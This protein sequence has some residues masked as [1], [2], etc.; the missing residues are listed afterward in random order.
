MLT[1]LRGRLLGWFGMILLPVVM[2]LGYLAS[3]TYRVGSGFDEARAVDDVAEAVSQ[4][5]QWTTDYSLTWKPDSLRTA[6]AWATRYRERSAR[7]RGLSGGPQ[8]AETLDELDRDFQAY[9]KLA[10]EMANAYIKFDRVVGNSFTDRFHVQARGLEEETRKLK[11]EVAERM[12][13]HLRRGTQIAITAS[14]LIVAIVVGGALAISAGLVRRLRAVLLTLQTLA[15]GEGDLTR[16]LTDR[17][18]DEIGTLARCF[19]VFVDKLQGII[20]QVVGTAAH[21]SSASAQLSAASV[22]LSGGTQAQSAGLEETAASLEQM[23]GTVQQNAENA[24]LADQLAGRAKGLAESGAAEIERAVSAM[25]GIAAAS[26]RISQIT[27]A[28]DEI[29]FQT[30]LLALNAAVE[31]ARAGEQGRGFAV[32]AAEVRSL[33]QRSAAAAKEIKSLIHEASEKVTEGSQQVNRSGETLQQIVSEV[34]RVADGIREIAR[35]SQ[36]QAQG[37]NQVNRAVAQMDGV[38]QANA[39]QTEQ[40]S[41]TAHALAD[42]ADRLQALVGRFTIDRGVAAGG[43][44]ARRPAPVSPEPVRVAVAPASRAP[45]DAGVV[46]GGVTAAGSVRSSHDGFDEF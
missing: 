34:T 38:V 12:R 15:D 35:A 6:E 2:I 21:V 14:A 41:S 43:S 1:G 42:Q 26:I 32:V 33:A 13:G 16:R 3:T 40:L 11:D 9:W 39:A 20:G 28:I 29:A 24:R 5:L 27:T 22:R 36:E 18:A 46:M 17:G 10:A 7:L 19:N 8:T 31:A 44:P 30:N 4:V 45:R 25:D 37:I 23:T